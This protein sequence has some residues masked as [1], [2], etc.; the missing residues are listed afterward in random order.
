MSIR[1]FPRRHLEGDGEMLLTSRIFWSSRILL[2]GRL[3]SEN[4]IICVSGGPDTNRFPL[5][6][7]PAQ[8]AGRVAKGVRDHPAECARSLARRPRYLQQGESP[9]LGKVAVEGDGVGDTQA[10]Y[11]VCRDE[12]PGICS[13]LLEGAN[14]SA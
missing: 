1:Q 9:V 8:G 11:G 14:T 6:F 12:L 7:L 2:I 3:A 10:R 4:G 13:C 5:R